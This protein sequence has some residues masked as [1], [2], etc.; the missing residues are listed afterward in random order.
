MEQE[1]LIKSIEE[2]RDKVEELIEREPEP[3]PEPEKPAPAKK[4]RSAWDILT[5]ISYI[6]LGLVTIFI[7]AVLILGNYL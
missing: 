7:I 1:E 4:K 2:S 6:V 5:I 3:E